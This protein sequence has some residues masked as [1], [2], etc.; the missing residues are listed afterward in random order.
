[1]SLGL[2]SEK[3][4]DNMHSINKRTKLIGLLWLLS[5]ITGGFALFY[6]RSHVIVTGNAAATAANIVASEF[7]FRAAIVSNLL[8]QVLLFFFGLNLYHLF[9][10]VDRFLARVLLASVMMTVTIAV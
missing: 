9:K 1:M 2:A 10:D 6:V 7:L 3:E 5:A 4:P 8:S